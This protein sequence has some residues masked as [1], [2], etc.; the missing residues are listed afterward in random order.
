MLFD[1]AGLLLEPESYVCTWRDGE[2]FIETA[3]LDDALPQA[4]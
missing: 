4:A 2:L 1:I 3:A